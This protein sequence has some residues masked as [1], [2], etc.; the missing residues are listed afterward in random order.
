[1]FV[2]WL[3]GWLAGWLVG[4]LSGDEVEVERNKKNG[5][6]VKCENENGFFVFLCD[7]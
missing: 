6:R 4:W 1:L 7:V 2:C 5:G 3:V